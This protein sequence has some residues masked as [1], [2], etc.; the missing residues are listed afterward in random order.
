[1]KW[2]LLLAVIAMSLGSGPG[3]DKDH[4]IIDK[5]VTVSG[6]VTDSVSGVALDSAGIAVFDTAQV[7]IQTDSTGAYRFTTWGTAAMVYAL[8]SG[9]KTKWQYAHDGDKIDFQLVPE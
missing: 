7:P 3:C 6:T 1:V 9:Y 8:K 4:K 2:I 5:A